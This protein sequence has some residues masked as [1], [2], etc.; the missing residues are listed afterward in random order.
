MKVALLILL[1]QGALGAFDTLWFHEWKE[2]LPRRGEARVELSLHA[3]RDF[4]YAVI[5]ATLPWFTWEGNWAAILLVLL[6]IEIVI[7]LAD[8]VVEDRTRPLSAGERITHAFMGIIYGAFLGH[9][10]PE[11]GRWWR[12]PTGFGTAEYGWLSV[13]LT[14]M[15]AGVALSGVRDL[16]AA[17]GRRR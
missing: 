15:A 14:V 11:I 3:C 16:A 5:F 13:V 8:F 17:V 12:Q 10:L 9:A 7:T 1:A 4:V 6:A 2:R